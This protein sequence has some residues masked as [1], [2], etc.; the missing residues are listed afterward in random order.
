ML[1]LLH[2]TVLYVHYSILDLIEFLL[3]LCQKN[4]HVNF[5]KSLARSIGAI[6]TQVNKGILYQLHTFNLHL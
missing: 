3:K 1:I 2:Y 4:L 6:F 5:I